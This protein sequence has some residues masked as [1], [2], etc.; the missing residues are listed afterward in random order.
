MKLYIQNYSLYKSDIDDI[1]IKKTLKQIY[2][3]DT[4][5][6]D[7]FIH[8]AVYGA[9]L[10][11][12]KTRISED[13]ELYV[14]SGVGNVSVVEK[15]NT[16]IYEQNQP[17]KLFDFL[18]LLGNTTS[19]YIAS[20][21]GIKGKNIFQISDN[22]T[23]I[24]SLISLYS[25]ITST[26]K[27]AILCSIDL[28]SS[29]DEIMKRVLGVDESCKIL[30]GVNYQKFSLEKEDAIGQLEFDI[31]SYSLD[32]IREI[33]ISTDIV[34]QFSNR[35]KELNQQKEFGFFETMASYAI[36][37]S[38]QKAKDMLYIDCFE[39]KYKILKLKSLR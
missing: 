34:P 39:D 14:T 38:L 1:E 6:Q 27:N 22:F 5:R 18:N 7:D 9:K 31:K 17:L 8:L 13:D 28:L 32:E 3:Y 36:N 35:C 26:K 24:N 20:A 4:R 37:N 23:Y 10:L 21:L 19:Y 29:P 15:T 33:I 12:E 30:S 16:N 11:K 2:K 25:S